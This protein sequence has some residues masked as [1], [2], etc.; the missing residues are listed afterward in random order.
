[1]PGADLLVPV[2]LIK[3]NGSR[4]SQE[5][6][7]D[8]MT[9][10]V[11]EK[12][13]LPTLFT[14]TL[15][16]REQKWI[17]SEDFSEGSEIK[18]EL[19]YL[20]ETVELFD[21]ELTGI[22]SDFPS[23][24]STT[25]TVRGYDRLHRL[26]RDKKTRTFT[27]MKDSQIAE[28]MAGE[29]SLETD[30]ESTTDTV[31][32]VLQN[33][34]TD[35]EFLLERSE[36]LGYEVG[37]CGAKLVFRKPKENL[38]GAAVLEWGKSLIEFSADVT[39]VGQIS[40]VVVRGWDPLNQTVIAGEAGSESQSTTMQGSQSG[41]ETA[42]QSF[43]ESTEVIVDNSIKTQSEA[44]NMAQ[45]RFR[46][47]SMNYITGEGRCLGDPNIRVGKIISLKGLGEKLTGDYY[48]VGTQHELTR[49][50]YVT[51]FQVKR[52]AR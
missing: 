40:K 10:S 25:L 14:M 33:A 31:E 43:G 48:I 28:Q 21:G 36:R 9:V 29:V 2:Y 24:G 37:V 39:S 19:G 6:A 15:S 5:M 18:V 34:Q 44:D 45:I 49:E 27:E 47:R 26:A 20:N 23:A 32:Y 11:E 12:M 46:D 35:L 3:I 16:D 22:K 13:D 30:V 8:I 50:G 38:S 51:E 4:I 17:D 7:A 42:E 41:S 1:M 52:N